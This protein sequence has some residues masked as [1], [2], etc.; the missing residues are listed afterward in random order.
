MSTSQLPRG[1]WSVLALFFLLAAAEADGKTLAGVDL[2]PRMTVDGETLV[3]THCG[4]RD[5][6]WIEFYVAS[7]YLPKQADPLHALRDPDILKLVRLDIVSTWALPD[8]VPEKYRSALR[9]E[10]SREPLRTVLAQY[11]RLAPG[12]VVLFR[13]APDTGVTMSV[14]GRQVMTDPGHDLIDAMLDAWSEPETGTEEKLQRL[15]LRHPC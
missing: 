15:L 12:D 13:Y 8:E 5:T 7:L 6:L 1:V 10:L 11:R 9:E 3:L 14:D 4:V 2:P